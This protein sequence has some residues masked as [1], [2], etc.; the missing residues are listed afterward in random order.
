MTGTPAGVGPVN[1]GETMLG[2]VAGVGNLT[3]KIG[4]REA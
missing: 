2:R 1:P 4:P 3:I